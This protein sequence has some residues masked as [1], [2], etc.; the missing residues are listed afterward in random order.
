MLQ[1]RT[2]HIERTRRRRHEH[3]RPTEHTTTPPK[4]DHHIIPY[5]VCCAFHRSTHAIYTLHSLCVCIVKARHALS[6]RCKFHN[7][8]ESSPQFTACSTSESGR[9]SKLPLPMSLIEIQIPGHRHERKHDF[10][11]AHSGFYIHTSIVWP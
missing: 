2:V 10:L 8:T 11:H 9:P 4:R 6:R 1:R 7:F 5:I 3:N